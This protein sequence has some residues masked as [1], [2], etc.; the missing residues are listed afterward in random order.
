MTIN[1]IVFSDEI[2]LWWDKEWDLPDGISYLATLDGKVQKSARSTHVTFADLTPESEYQIALTRVLLDGT[3][4]E[5][6]NLKLQTAKAKNRL[7]VTKAPYNCASD[8]ETLVTKGLQRAL[9]DCTEND[10]VYLPR[11]TY[12]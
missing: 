2:T 10:C 11:G 8:G 9:D 12:I 6:A 4:E 7:D 3:Q 1:Q 5:I